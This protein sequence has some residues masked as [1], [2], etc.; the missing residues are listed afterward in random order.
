MYVVVWSILPIINEHETVHGVFLCLR[1]ILL[2]NIVPALT[3]LCSDVFGIKCNVECLP[4]CTIV[5]TSC[6]MAMVCIKIHYIMSE[7]NVGTF[8]TSVMFVYKNPY[9]SLQGICYYSMNK[10]RHR[11]SASLHTL[12]YDSCRFGFGFVVYILKGLKPSSKET[13]KENYLLYKMELG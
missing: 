8:L 10:P 4:P 5:V 9:S 11:N 13:M 7:K 2:L 6:G 3:G 1:I 12:Y